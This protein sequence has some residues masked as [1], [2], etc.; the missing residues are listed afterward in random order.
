MEI[1]NALYIMLTHVIFSESNFYTVFGGPYRE[2]ALIKWILIYITCL[3]TSAME[4]FVV[5]PTLF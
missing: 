1:G 5:F 4:Q 2:D 3:A